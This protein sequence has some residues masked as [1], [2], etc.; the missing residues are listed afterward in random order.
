MGK[1]EHLGRTRPHAHYEL[2]K[3]AE[4]IREGHEDVLD[5]WFPKR[6]ENE[7]TAT[8]EDR[9]SRAAEAIAS[10]ALLWNIGADP[11]G[12]LVKAFALRDRKG[13]GGNY[14][15]HD[16]GRLA[17]E[18]Y[19]MA[20]CLKAANNVI[21]KAPRLGRALVAARKERR[22]QW[23]AWEI[24]KSGFG[25][26]AEEVKETLYDGPATAFK[27][28]TTRQARPDVSVLV[29]PIRALV[30]RRGVFNDGEVL[31]LVRK[32]RPLL[33]PALTL[34]SLKNVALTAKRAEA[35]RLR[36]MKVAPLSSPA[37]ADAGTAP[38]LRWVLE[39][40]PPISCTPKAFH[41]LPSRLDTS[42]GQSNGQRS[43]DDEEKRTP[44]DRGP[45]ARTGSAAD[46]GGGSRPGAEGAN[47]PGTE[48]AGRRAEVRPSFPQS[49]RI[50]PRFSGSVLR[51][52]YLRLKRRGAG[53]RSPWRGI[54]KPP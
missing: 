28:G 7:S 36:Q 12:D 25:V 33:P 29:E 2:A 44:R 13:W 43:R 49:H 1:K 18:A 34:K 4:A 5:Q 11:M 35:H 52:A 51:R 6:E 24:A 37:F 48:A 54:G 38:F 17:L 45:L 31:A 46:E 40:A 27:G 26:W 3:A 20:L 22:R 10:R 14:T 23:K 42:S 21:L 9:L 19:G 32:L 53:G 39:V 8:R 47:A 30:E 16:A 50:H 15:D 41:S